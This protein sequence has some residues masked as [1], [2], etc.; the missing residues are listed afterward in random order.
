VAEDNFLRQSQLVGSFG[1]GSFADLPRRSVM[2]SG[3]DE[4]AHRTQDEIHDDR[5]V[6]KLAR[7]LGI[8]N[9]QLFSPPP[10]DSAREAEKLGVS[11]RLYPIWFV[12]NE[13]A[14]QASRFGRRRLIRIEGT[15]KSGLWYQDPDDGKRKALTPIRFVRACRKGHTNDVDW[16][17]FVHRGAVACRQA[18]WL[19]ERGTSG[20]VADTWIGCDCGA[21]RQLYEALDLT[22]Q[23]LGN[24]D[25]S[26]PWLGAYSKE[27][28]G[29][30]NRLLVRS[31]SNAYFAET[32]SAIS[33]PDRDEELANRLGGLIDRIKNVTT[34]EQLT[35]LKEIQPEVSTALAGLS[36]ERVLEFIA[37]RRDG[38]IADV[39]V[40]GAEFAVLASGIAGKDEPGSHY[41][42][43]SL[44]RDD[45]D[46]NA[47]P[48]LAAIENVVL[49][50]R[51]REVVAQIGFTRFESS[52]P[53]IDGE[54]DTQVQRQ[55]IA[56]DVKWLP[57]AEHRGEG[58]FFQVSAAAIEA[59]L[60]R[61]ATKERLNELASGFALWA[62]EKSIS[63]PF[64][65]GP[66]I[67]LHSLSHLLISAIAMDCGYPATSLRERVY[68]SPDGYGILI[69]TGS[70]DSEGTLG[71]LVQAGRRLRDHLYHALRAGR[72]CSNDPVCSEHQADNA[73]E[74]RFLHGGACHACLLIAEPSCE[75][76]NDLLDRALV[77]DTVRTCGA[78]FFP[79]PA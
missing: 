40:K 4:W 7:A 6:G 57:A 24:C 53:D 43:Q 5:L 1:P 28:C 22:T 39:S 72:L 8:T 12:T 50:H 14:A 64:V 15:E 62:A 78:A 67:L 36:E 56:L 76:R 79:N 55:S 66:Y 37:A 27:S 75:H 42:A 9:L 52:S 38:R 21:L 44:P 23:P 25:G 2:I 13:N 61:D 20:E 54:L 29:E 48:M 49:V 31:A 18:L 33:L 46:P 65:G 30:P 58:V 35:M 70:T 11:A 63:H 10:F 34:R 45:W 74:K 68:A 47:E 41:F 71:G 26:R 32:M 51:L 77:V 59:W 60:Q 69:H 19:E 73:Y 16:R 3:L 17:L